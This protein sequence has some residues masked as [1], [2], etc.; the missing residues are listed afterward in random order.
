M[1]ARIVDNKWVYIEQI[2]AG[3][4]VILDREFSVRIPNAKYID[5]SVGFFDGVYHKYNKFKHRIA[6]P[7]LQ[8]LIRICDKY[9]LPLQIVDSRDPPKYKQPDPNS[10]TDDMLPGITLD[11]H[12]VEGIK[13]ACVNEVGCILWGTGG[14]KSEAIAAIAKAYNCPTVILC[15][16]KTVVDQL[17]QRLELRKVVEEVGMFY[18][19]KRPNGQQ[20][21]VGSIQSL[22]IPAGDPITKGPK[23]YKSDTPEKYAKK[24]K[25]FK[26]RCKNAKLLR[27]IIGKCELLLVDEGDTA[28]GASWR[29]LFR[30][31][32]NGRYKFGFTG[33]I[34][35]KS[36]PVQRMVLKEHLGSVIHEADRRELESINRIIP[37]RYTA[38]AFGD[39]SLIRDRTAFDI[40]V[41]E[42]MIENPKYHMIVKKLAERSLTEPTD[43]VLILVESKPLG[44]TLEAMI[45]DS[46]FICGDHPMKT[47]RS[48]IQDFES[49]KIKV[50]I[51]G[52]IV[53]RGMDLKG[54]CET[55][56]IATGGKLESEFT[57]KIGRAVR[58]NHRG[59]AQ[60]YD[61]ILLC[62]YYLWAHS[63]MRLKVIAK[64]GYPGKIVFKHAT[65]DLQKFVNSRFRRP[66][67]PKQ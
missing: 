67:P 4:E 57:Q 63:R 30:N 39:E 22:V 1:L 27:D 38:L 53:R 62:S 40:A 61:I 66:K 29:N 35:D 10:I 13:A 33:T 50:L 24:L 46:K 6:R 14:G 3:D 54:G 36:K 16:M 45:P 15:E 8:D 26:T 56:I 12:Q 52:K 47:R 2:F 55:L 18:A 49:R 25:A 34:P 5:M 20:V 23:K 9:G 51:G 11:R 31:W 42:H 60:I 7:L 37:F 59:Y 43:G 28:V 65:V 32:Y 64:M 58:L 44:Y 41:K 21:I 48:I 19:G 17:K